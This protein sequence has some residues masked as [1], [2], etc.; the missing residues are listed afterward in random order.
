ML[1]RYVDDLVAGNEEIGDLNA[2][3]ERVA[4]QVKDRLEA[5]FQSRLATWKTTHAAK[6]V[7]PIASKGAAEAASAPVSQVRQGPRTKDQ[8][9]AEAMAFLEQWN[10]KKG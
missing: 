4:V 2:H 1:R 8:E 10:A 9:R 5:M 3:F 7:A 6:A